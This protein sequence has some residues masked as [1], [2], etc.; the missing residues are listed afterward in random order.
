MISV[1]FKSCRT[2]CRPSS[3]KICTAVSQAAPTR[4]PQIRTSTATANECLQCTRRG[5]RDVANA[6]QVTIPSRHSIPSQNKVQ[7]LRGSNTASG[8][9][10]QCKN[11]PRAW[12]VSA[13]ALG[14]GD[15]PAPMAIAKEATGG[16][17]PHT[18]PTRRGP[19]SPVARVGSN[20]P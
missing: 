16:P 12:A 18:T 6:W 2:S 4:L 1:M 5:K 3:P 20:R 19:F 14:T 7:C 8:R 17:L 10:S 15:A 9:G 13:C 11:P